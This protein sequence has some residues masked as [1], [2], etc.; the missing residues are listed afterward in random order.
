MKKF[1]T[2]FILLNTI[3]AMVFIAIASLYFASTSLIIS[4]L[5]LF[6]IGS[7]L[8][9]KKIVLFAFTYY[10][11]FGV[12]LAISY[13]QVFG[14][15]YAA[16]DDYQFYLKALASSNRAI[17]DV[18]ESRYSFYI[19]FLVF[20]IK[21]MRM[22]GA[23]PIFFDLIIF[24]VFI[25]TSIPVLIKKILIQIGEYKFKTVVL[26]IV[27]P[28]TTYYCTN[29]L[30]DSLLI[31]TFLGVFLALLNQKSGS[32]VLA[33]LSIAISMLITYFI[34]PSNVLLFF[35]FILLFYMKKNRSAIFSV[36]LIVLVSG[37]MVSTFSLKFD[38][39]LGETTTEYQELRTKR[40]YGSNSIGSYILN[41]SS[42]LFYPVKL[43]YIISNG[44]PPIIGGVNFHNLFLTIGTVLVY[45]MLISI[46]LSLFDANYVHFSLT[47]TYVLYVVIIGLII[48]ITSGDPR[49]VQFLYPF[50]LVIGNRYLEFKKDLFRNI[51]ILLTIAGVILVCFY[52]F[53]KH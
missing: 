34:R 53:Y 39:S 24:K 16:D 15:P 10:I 25:S 47:K 14:M 7:L 3:L 44:P 37:I 46:F 45:V 23:D 22:L 40:S 8:K 38:R 35:I 27:F 18:V 49:H 33:F 11:I 30:R 4:F 9:E 42:P 19:Q 2:D 31:I 41:N 12:V 29:L 6:F 51:S 17:G 5:V 13:D 20:W 48:S 21:F 32:N 1:S 28:V 52:S 36:L 50:L 43:V 26:I